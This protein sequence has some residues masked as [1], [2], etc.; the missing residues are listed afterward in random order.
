MLPRLSVSLLGNWCG[1]AWFRPS[2]D[3]VNQARSVDQAGRQPALLQ[4]LDGGLTHHNR[5]GRGGIGVDPRRRD[6]TCSAPLS[7]LAWVSHPSRGDSPATALSPPTLTSM[8]SRLIA[9]RA[10]AAAMSEVSAF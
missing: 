10:A 7:S 6:H 9:D 4:P 5:R 1:L 3:P 2:R 8:P